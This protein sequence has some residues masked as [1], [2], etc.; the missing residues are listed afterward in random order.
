MIEISGKAAKDELLRSYLVK[1]DAI[2]PPSV[3]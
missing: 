2:Y 3:V 1:E